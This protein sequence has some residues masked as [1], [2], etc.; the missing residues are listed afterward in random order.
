MMHSGPRRRAT[1]GQPYARHHLLRGSQRLAAAIRPTLGPVPRLVAV[2][3]EHGAGTP[4]LLDDGGVIARRVLELPDP[5][6]NMGAMHLR[7]A[8]WAVHERAGDGTAT[9][10]VIYQSVLEQGVRHLAAG[11]DPAALRASLLHGLAYIVDAIHQQAQP[12]RQSQDLIEAARTLHLD[13]AVAAVLA[14]AFAVIGEHGQV[15]VRDALDGE[16][17]WD[18]V[19]GSPWPTTVLT[20]AI[21]AERPTRGLDLVHCAVIAS[22]ATI[23]NPNVIKRAVSAAREAGA[24]GLLL[25]AGGL[26]EPCR[27]TLATLRRASGF[28]TIAVRI[29]GVSDL[30]REQAL[31]DI[32]ALTG[33]RAF[34]VAAGDEMHRVQARDVGKA[35]R[36]WVD[37]QYFS[38]VRGAGKPSSLRAHVNRLRAAWANGTEDVDARAVLSQR[39]ARLTGATAVMYVPRSRGVGTASDEAAIGQACKVMRA[40]I[41]DGTVPG[42]GA[43][44][45]ECRRVLEQAYG[46]PYAAADLAAR[47]ILVAALG[48]PCKAIMENA[49]YE[50]APILMALGSRDTPHCWDALTGEIV[51]VK[52]ARIRD[53]ASTLSTAVATAVTAAAQVLSIDLLVHPAHPEEAFW[54]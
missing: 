18:I 20:P 51:A 14:E 32:E 5:D 31:V 12:V 10:C 17:H 29:P 26:S 21:L 23:G 53:A 46:E 24:Q 13:R 19:D 43:A 30:D 9:A 6:E 33:C 38:L 54:P 44:Y 45:L 39:L 11:I 27:A 4:D 36:V 28:E 48:E 15:L 35:R 16:I 3:P 37:R 2:A 8:L 22:D 52:D 1:V 40:I 7:H 50:P 49:G 25:I 34:R 47:D 41:R 42:A